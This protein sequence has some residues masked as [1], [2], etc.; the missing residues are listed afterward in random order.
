M[1]YR[2]LH[3]GAGRYRNHKYFFYVQIVQNYFKPDRLRQRYLIEPIAGQFFAQDVLVADMLQNALILLVAHATIH[4]P[5]RAAQIPMEGV[6]AVR[7]KCDVR[8]RR[9]SEIRSRKADCEGALLEQI[10]QIAVVTT[11]RFYKQM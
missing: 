3:N 10:A 1:D 5:D 9:W 7:P 11:P 4:H 6:M 2:Q 8:C